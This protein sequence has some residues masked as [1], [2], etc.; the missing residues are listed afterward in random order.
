MERNRGS[1][2]DPLAGGSFS[3]SPAP[4]QRPSV[5]ARGSTPACV[6]ARAKSDQMELQPMKHR[7][8]TILS[9][10]ALAVFATAAGAQTA[11][12]PKSNDNLQQLTEVVVT[13]SMIARPESET[14]EAITI[15]TA[16]TLKNLGIVNVEQALDTIT[17]NTPSLNI[18]QSVG[19]FT[20][21]GTYANL[22]DL[23][24][25]R[26]LV[27]L[28]GHR[29]ANNA[30]FGNAVDLSGIPFSAIQTVQVLREGAAALYGSDA[31][32]GVVNFITKKDYRGAE[33]DATLDHPQEAGGESGDIN[34]SFGHGSLAR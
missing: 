17:S 5:I 31:I 25:G 26:T 28:D 6:S 30:F 32:A 8:A 18:A 12:P 33:V 29:L 7:I 9:A 20:G 19:T 4:A 1:I 21:G 16:S 22:R 3:L 10:G 13:G 23:G 27:L 24:Q 34:F 2:S 11:P 14:A 15:V